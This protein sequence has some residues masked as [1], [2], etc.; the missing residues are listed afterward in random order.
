MGTRPAGLPL[1]CL[2]IKAEWCREIF[3]NGKTW[4]IRGQA[5]TK[6]NVRVCVA[7]SKAKALVGEVTLVDCLLV[8]ERDG[9]G[10]LVPASGCPD[11]IKNFLCN[12]GN[13]GKHRIS[14][15][16]IVKY[17]KKIFAWVLADARRYTVAV[18]FFPA[19]ALGSVGFTNLTDELFDVAADAAAKAKRQA[20]R[21]RRSATSADRRI[22]SSRRTVSRAALSG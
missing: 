6:R 8:A 12:P 1:Q 17:K 2:T 13:F 15:F 19:V 3:E 14:D 20:K 5:T 16:S 21:V 22:R 9:R 10:N 18:P 7:Q 4:E 11:A